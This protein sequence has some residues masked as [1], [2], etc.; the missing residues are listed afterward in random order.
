VRSG[1][2]VQ[3]AWLIGYAKPFRHDA[4]HGGRR[5]AQSHD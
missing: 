2:G 3:A 5:G 1:S 4:N